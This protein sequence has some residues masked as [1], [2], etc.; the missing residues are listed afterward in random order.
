MTG[1]N[2]VKV[3]LFHPLARRV[4][5]SFDVG[6]R[7]K[8]IVKLLDVSE[9]RSLGFR[10]TILGPSTLAVLDTMQIQDTSYKMVSDTREILD[11]STTDEHDRVLLNIMSL[12]GNVTDDC[13]AGR[14]LDTCNF[15][16]CGIRFLR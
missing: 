15:S 1:S 13:A 9:L 11:S 2:L 12:T 5:E 7:E 3:K 4:P 16:H 8:E 6:E 10:C 14:E